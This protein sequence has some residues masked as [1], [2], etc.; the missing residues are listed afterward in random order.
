[1][2]R[3]RRRGLRLR[4]VCGSACRSTRA[5][6][7]LDRESIRILQLGGTF[8]VAAI[9]DSIFGAIIVVL[10]SKYLGVEALSA[11]VVASL[12]LGLSDTCTGG[13]A[14][15]LTTVCSHAI[16]AKN[17]NLAGQYL[18]IAMV[19]YFFLSV[20]VMGVWWFFMEDCILS[21]GMSEYVAKI[22]ADYAKVAMFDYLIAGQFESFAVILDV[23]GYAVPATI[24][25]IVAN[26]ID[27]AVVW[28]LF[29]TVEGMDLFW[30]GVAHLVSST[31]F[32]TIFFMIGYCKGWLD[33][34]WPGLTKTNAL[35]NT[36]AVKYVINT[37]IPITMGDLLEYGEVSKIYI[38]IVF[39]CKHPM[40]SDS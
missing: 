26:A 1:M 5:I 27:C 21:F 23:S 20:L 12:L 28:I 33:P 15:A 39:S 37:A 14:N 36:S 35:K 22:G 30:M 10:I 40:V 31:F 3:T 2:K 9:V 17:Y 34:F 4:R 19:V 8:T 7:A 25:D 29:A 32:F 24:F 11:C 6:S 18:Q 16:G 38:I 13:I